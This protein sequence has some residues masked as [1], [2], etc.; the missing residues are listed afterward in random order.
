M[1]HASLGRFLLIG[2]PL[3]QSPALPHS[4]TVPAKGIAMLPDTTGHTERRHVASSCHDQATVAAFAI[5]EASGS[6]IDAGRL[7][8]IRGVGD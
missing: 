5:L 4:A 7:L 8:G 6:A 1:D 3:S 2:D